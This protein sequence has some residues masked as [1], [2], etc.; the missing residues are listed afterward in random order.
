M[1]NSPKILALKKVS[2]KEINRAGR[3]EDQ[4][5]L[6]EK[7]ISNTGKAIPVP[8]ISLRTQQVSALLGWGQNS[9]IHV[10]L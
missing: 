1:E 5:V 3:K 10:F 7:D 9:I 4:M 6:D 2:I 8:S